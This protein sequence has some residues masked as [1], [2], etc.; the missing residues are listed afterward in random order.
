MDSCEVNALFLSFI[1]LACPTLSYP[2]E[3]IPRSHSKRVYQETRV[4]VCKAGV[5]RIS[6][7][8]N[9]SYT[10]TFQIMLVLMWFILERLPEL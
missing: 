9:G 7:H 2:L 4:S 3:P 8:E 6:L 1:P 10:I 5:I